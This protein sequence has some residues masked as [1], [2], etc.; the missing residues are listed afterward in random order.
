MEFARRGEDDI[1]LFKKF[2]VPFQ[3]GIGVIDVKT[4]EVESAGLRRRSHSPRARSD[5]PPSGSIIN[6]GLRT[7]A[8]AA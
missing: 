4:N 3:V 8:S 7:R 6:P 1:E 5:W 2:N